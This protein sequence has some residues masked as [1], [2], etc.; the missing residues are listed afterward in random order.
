MTSFITVAILSGLLALT[1][2][3]KNV[4]YMPILADSGF[5]NKRKVPYTV[6]FAIPKNE[7][8]DNYQEEDGDITM[9]NFEVR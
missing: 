2:Q 3:W 6:T 1:R 4:L 8:M 5:K 9:D 7:S